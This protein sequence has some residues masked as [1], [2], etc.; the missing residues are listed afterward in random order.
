MIGQDLESLELTIIEY[1]WVSPPGADAIHDTDL[2]ILSIVQWCSLILYALSVKQ[3]AHLHKF[4]S[5]FLHICYQHLQMR[6]WNFFDFSDI[7]SPLKFEATILQVLG[8]EVVG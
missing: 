3:N 8:E 4:D 5:S 2:S 6:K 7:L 1:H